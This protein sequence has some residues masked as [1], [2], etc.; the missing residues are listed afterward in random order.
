[1]RKL[2]QSESFPVTESIVTRPPADRDCSSFSNLTGTP[3]DLTLT[4][5]LDNVRKEEEGQWR[6]ELTNDAGTGHK[7]FTLVVA[8][9]QGRNA[10]DQQFH[11]RIRDDVNGPPFADARRNIAA[12]PLYNV[13]GAGLLHD[14]PEG[15]LK[16]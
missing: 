7:N 2:N 16:L 5:R 6:L 1:M 9:R 8:D 15:I 11:R 3:P 4:V 14:Y 12:N 13:T 10:S